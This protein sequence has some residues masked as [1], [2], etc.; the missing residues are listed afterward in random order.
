MNWIP[1]THQ[2]QNKK[3]TMIK[4]A[5]ITGASKG[6]GKA[7]AEV[8]AKQGYSL[9]LIARTTNELEDLKN[10][11]K[12][13]YQC[14]SKI[15]SLDVS[16]PDSV[17]I[18]LDVFQ[19][20]IP[21]LD[22][23]VN[24]AGFGISKKFTEML[25]VDMHDIMAVNMQFLTRLTYTILPFMVKNGRGKI[26]NVASI[27][28]FTPGPF[29]AMY[30][31]S[32]AYV[33][34]LSEALHQEYKHQGISISAL[35]PGITKSS[36]HQRAGRTS[37]TKSS[38]IT[39]SAESVAEIGYKGLMQNKRVIVSGSINKV[40]VFFMKIMPNFLLIKIAANISST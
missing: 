18:I 16:K 17:N 2:N 39:M 14:E 15:L 12:N 27:A 33:L 3:L 31:A 25:E 7:L 8:F 29:M 10:D 6:I 24:N 40:F 26:L 23:L 37:L 38:F 19:L 20:E 30:Y 28:A 22:V 1:L 4:T 32:K 34:S 11:L 35:C 21:T 9:I 36:F 5:L 13:R